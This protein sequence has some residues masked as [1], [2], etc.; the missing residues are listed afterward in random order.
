MD[1]MATLDLKI[2]SRAQEDTQALY[3]KQIFEKLDVIS[4]KGYSF[5]E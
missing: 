1:A 3:S 4:R 5:V 2:T